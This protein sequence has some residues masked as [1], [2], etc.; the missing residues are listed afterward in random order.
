MCE[1]IMKDGR[2]IAGNAEPT[3]LHICPGCAEEFF[4][5]LKKDGWGG[6]FIHEDGRIEE[7][8]KSGP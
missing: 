4:N 7:V 8:G 1:P 6:I 5:D 3:D 2:C